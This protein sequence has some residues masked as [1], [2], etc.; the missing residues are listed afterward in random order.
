MLETD[1]NDSHLFITNF[2]QLNNYY[3]ISKWNCGVCKL[4]L[5][6]I[7]PPPLRIHIHSSP[8]ALHY[9][10]AMLVNGRQWTLS[11][12]GYKRNDANCRYSLLSQTILSIA[13][14]EHPYVITN[15]PFIL[16]IFYIQ[17]IKKFWFSKYKFALTF[18]H[19]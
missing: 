5:G 14:T 11:R 19:H 18:C 10:S 7:P 15:Q 13:E 9:L 3:A 2:G 1:I 8:G 4:C 6:S 16:F 17:S 12:Y